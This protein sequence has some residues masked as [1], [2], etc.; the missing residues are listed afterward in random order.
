MVKQATPTT[1]MNMTYPKE[2]WSSLMFSSDDSLF[3]EMTKQLEDDK[4]RA[5][6]KRKTPTC[7]VTS[8]DASVQDRDTLPDIVHLEKHS[9]AVTGLLMLGVEP[10]QLDADI[11]NELVMPVNKPKQPDISKLSTKNGSKYNEHDNDRKIKNKKNKKKKDCEPW[12]R[13]ARQKDKTNDVKSMTVFPSLPKG[14]GSP[15]GILK[16]T[17]YKLRKGSPNKYVHKPLKCSMCDKMV[18]SKDELRS[19][20]QE[21]HNIISCNECGKGF[22]TKQSLRKHS[23]S[24]TTTNNYEC[25][26]CKEYFTFPSELDAHMIK[27]DIMPNFSCNIVGCDRAYF[28]KAELTAHI[29]THDGK[30]WQ[31]KHKDCKFEALDKR[32]LTAHKRKHSDTLNYFCRH[33]EEKFKYFEQHK[34]HEK[35]KHGE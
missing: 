14:P 26:R 35:T 8:T 9:D 18:N 12:Q 1:S 33:C 21:V 13:S 28:R 24:H 32:Y 27:H 6:E 5:S 4:D 22:T 17:R 25:I 34:R 23:Y 29:K 7:T 15:K 16:V 3:E 2:D 11:D 30:L 10:E 31:C 20:H 19:H